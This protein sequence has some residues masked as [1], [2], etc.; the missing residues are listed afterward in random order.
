[1]T[2][3][4]QEEIEAID[5]IVNAIGASQN[6]ELR[7]IVDE[8]SRLKLGWKERSGTLDAQQLRGW[9]SVAARRVC[10][11]IE[12]LTGEL[13]HSVRFVEC[14]NT[15]LRLETPTGL[16]TAW[17]NPSEP[18]KGFKK[19]TYVCVNTAMMSSNSGNERK[20]KINM[21]VESLDSADDEPEIL[22]IA[23]FILDVNVYRAKKNVPIACSHI[24]VAGGY[25]RSNI[26]I[27]LMQLAMSIGKKYKS[28]RITIANV[29]VVS[30]VIVDELK[31]Y[32][33]KRVGDYAH[34]A[35]PIW[36]REITDE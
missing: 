9:A 32:P 24:D 7:K 16:G 8:L 19:L 15:V 23:T 31:M 35:E 6:P 29:N 18:I 22:A 28:D 3:L 20:V 27:V 30:G 14:I 25:E 2:K 17:G 5:R 12:T 21:T 1:M 33:I 36:Y 10:E 4:R 34:S 13:A 11:S 26:S